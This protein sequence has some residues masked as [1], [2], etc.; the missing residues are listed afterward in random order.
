MA[1]CAAISSCCLAR[2]SAVD[3]PAIQPSLH[4]TRFLSPVLAAAARAA[5]CARSSILASRTA[6]MGSSAS[7]ARTPDPNG[8]KSGSYEASSSSSSSSRTWILRGE[9]DATGSSN[10]S[11]SSSSSSRSFSSPRSI[12]RRSLA[13]RNLSTSSSNG[14]VGPDR[15]APNDA[16]VVVGLPVPLGF[17]NASG[18]RVG[19]NPNRRARSVAFFVRLAASDF[20]VLVIGL[21]ASA[22]G[23]SARGLCCAGGSPSRLADPEVSAS[24][25]KGVGRPVGSAGLAGDVFV[26]TDSN[27]RSSDARVC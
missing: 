24:W 10:A 12:L 3:V 26:G 25:D 19:W 6:W 11:S 4:P 5:R 18:A 7:L 13:T 8:S 17:V 2:T 22:K 1:S 9:S 16:C 21:L 20:C 14:T 23:T 15:G 27:V